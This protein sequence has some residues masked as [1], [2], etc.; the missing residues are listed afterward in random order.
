M[1]DF[2][3]AGDSLAAEGVRSNVGPARTAARMVR[4]S[5]LP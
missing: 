2:A 3:G 1:R 4:E 5:H